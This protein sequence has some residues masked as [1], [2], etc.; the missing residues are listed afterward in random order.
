MLCN[1]ICIYIYHTCLS[2]AAGQ[3]LANVLQGKLR[4]LLNSKFLAVFISR[5]FS[6]IEQ[7]NRAKSIN[8]ALKTILGGFFLHFKH[9]PGLCRKVVSL[10]SMHTDKRKIELTRVS[11]LLDTKLV[12]LTKFTTVLGPILDTFSICLNSIETQNSVFCPVKITSRI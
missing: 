5:D 10:L 8:T 1:I 12:F 3:Y 4:T 6:N 2:A 11:V 9:T 7:K